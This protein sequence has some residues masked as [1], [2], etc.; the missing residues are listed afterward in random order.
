M[1]SAEPLN[2]FVDPD[3]KP[4]AIHKAAIIPIY[5]KAKV[6]ADL[7]DDMKSSF[8]LICR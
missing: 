7:E 8:D 1:K 3:V 2:L 4:V 5:L 6:K